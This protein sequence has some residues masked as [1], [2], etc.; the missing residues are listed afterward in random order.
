MDEFSKEILLAGYRRYKGV[1]LKVISEKEDEF[2]VEFDHPTDDA[3]CGTEPFPT[4]EEAIA[5]AK[6]LIDDQLSDK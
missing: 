4:I 3:V 6:Q 2:F 5:D 1:F